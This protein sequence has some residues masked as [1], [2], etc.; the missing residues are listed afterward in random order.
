MCFSPTSGGEVVVSS[1]P[2]QLLPK[3]GVVVVVVVV[4]WKHISLHNSEVNA[5]SPTS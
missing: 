5:H 3:P 4:Q 1:P 2:P